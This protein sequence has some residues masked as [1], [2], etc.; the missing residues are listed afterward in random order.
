M[1]GFSFINL[2]MYL[3]YSFGPQ[4]KVII[5]SRLMYLKIFITELSFNLIECK[6]TLV[7][8]C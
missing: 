6:P 7:E 8:P 2:F 4:S 5:H 3:K 1:L